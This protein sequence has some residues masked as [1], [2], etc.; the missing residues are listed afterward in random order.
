MTCKQCCWN[1]LRCL[2]TT[3]EMLVIFF[4]TVIGTGS[5]SM[6]LVMLFKYIPKL[7]HLTDS[8][9]LDLPPQTRHQLNII[10]TTMI[11]HMIS[12]FYFGFMLITFTQKQK[13]CVICLF[14]ICSRKEE[15]RDEESVPEDSSTSTDSTTKEQTPRRHRI[16]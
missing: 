10:I 1:V 14:Q 15:T 12:N 3:K 4:T 16:R 13:R 7:I 2:F 9:V 5:I 11:L 6:S 8:S